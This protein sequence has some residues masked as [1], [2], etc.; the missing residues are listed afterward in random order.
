MDISN[1]YY[2]ILFKKL[3]RNLDVKIAL[4][5]VEEVP[6]VGKALFILGSIFTTVF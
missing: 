1:V 3:L 6:L 4:Q 5:V 2:C